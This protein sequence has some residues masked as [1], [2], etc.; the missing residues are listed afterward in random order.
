MCFSVSQSVYLSVHVSKNKK[1]ES[2]S[3]LRVMS[4]VMGNR[5]ASKFSFRGLKGKLK[6]CD[7]KLWSAIQG[8]IK[9]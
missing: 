9:F 5:L 8:K 7:L 3:A 1:E 6:F 4:Q 2:K